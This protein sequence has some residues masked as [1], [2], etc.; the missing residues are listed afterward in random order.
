MKHIIIFA[1]ILFLISCKKYLD[2]KPDIKLTVPT[3]VDDFQKLLDDP[4]MTENAA[5]QVGDLGSDDYYMS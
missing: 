2:E 4:R 3:S 5:P 1:S